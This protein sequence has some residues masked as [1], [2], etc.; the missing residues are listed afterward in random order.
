MAAERNESRASELALRVTASLLRHAEAVVRDCEADALLVY[1]DAIEDLPA[2]WPES[3][4]DKVIT[5]TR[6]DD[7]DRDQEER[8]VRHIRVPNVTLSRVGQVK[9]AL[10]L[11]LSRGLVQPR[12]TVVFLTGISGSGSLDTLIV[13]SIGDEH[14][15]VHVPEGDDEAPSPV[16]P[17]VLERA[18]SLAVALGSEGREGHSVG[19]IFVLGDSERVTSLSRQLILNPFAGYPESQRNILDPALEETIKE[20][21]TIDG[22]FIIRRDGVIVSA[23]TYLKTSSQGEDALPKGLGARH[24]AAAGITAVSDALAVVISQSTGTVSVF[25]RGQVLTSIERPKAATPTS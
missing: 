12:D 11:A 16:S 21:A 8:H 7:E 4:C 3:L 9:M 22:A 18:I 17:L 13:T 20:F 23:G 19:G 1:G 2:E 6:T 15:M 10:F 24:H 25:R 14:E 5:I